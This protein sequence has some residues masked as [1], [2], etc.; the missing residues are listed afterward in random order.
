MPETGGAGARF[1]LYRRTALWAAL[2]MPKQV[3]AP[4]GGTSL[5]AVSPA[6]VPSSAF[7]QLGLSS[8]GGLGPPEDRRSSWTLI[9]QSG[10]GLYVWGVAKESSAAA[11]L[12]EETGAGRARSAGRVWMGRGLE[13]EGSCILG[14]S[15]ICIQLF[16]QQ[17]FIEPPLA[18]HVFQA[19]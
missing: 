14:H 1:P 5:P 16:I 4:P 11:S 9:G 6:K 12:E 7:I 8:R 19:L 10:Q 15:G 13:K 2:A 17:T 3:G 18:P